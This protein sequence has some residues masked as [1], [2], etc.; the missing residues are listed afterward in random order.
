MLNG[1]LTKN[2]KVIHNMGIN[3][4][5]KLIIIIIQNNNNNE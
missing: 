4:L 3:N 2:I 1:L 5:K